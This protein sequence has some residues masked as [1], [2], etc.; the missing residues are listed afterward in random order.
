MIDNQIQ[1][2]IFIVEEYASH[3][4]QQNIHNKLESF[5]FTCVIQVLILYVESGIEGFNSAFSRC[6]HRP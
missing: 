4:F 5:Y 1:Q 3:W 2:I 6:A